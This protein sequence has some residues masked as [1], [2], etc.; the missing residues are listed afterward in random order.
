MFEGVIHAFVHYTRMLDEA[1]DAL[2]HGATFF[3][4]QLGL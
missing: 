3:R 2:E 1:N 4:Q